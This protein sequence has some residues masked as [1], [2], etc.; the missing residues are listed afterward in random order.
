MKKP[1]TKIVVLTLA[2]VIAGK[3][4]VFRGH[5]FIKGKAVV[6]CDDNRLA[7]I[8]NGFRH[9]LPIEEPEFLEPNEGLLAYKEYCQEAGVPIDASAVH[10]LGKAKGQVDL[11]KLKEDPKR[12]DADEKDEPED[13]PD[14]EP[15]DDE[16]L[17]GD[18]EVLV[19]DD[20]VLVDDEVP[21][22]VSRENALRIALSQLDSSDP[23]HWTSTDL[24]KLDVVN[25]ML[26]VDEHDTNR[27]ELVK[28]FPEFKRAR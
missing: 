8:L 13:E 25:E 28:L 14:D 2:G 23:S 1:G 9:R 4:H 24:P 6:C 7:A 3:D 16:A 26:P 19:G 10:N 18:D 22:E 20:E 17:V 5:K 12:D 15:D 21:A 11:G 27:K